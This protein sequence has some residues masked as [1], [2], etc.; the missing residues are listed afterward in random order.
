MASIALK[1]IPEEVKERIEDLTDRERRSLNQQALLLLERALVE[2][3][4]EF[5]RAYRCFREAH[6][7]SLLK[8]GDLRG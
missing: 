8:H 5:E 2:E 1:G 4:M 7:P 3:P 6:G